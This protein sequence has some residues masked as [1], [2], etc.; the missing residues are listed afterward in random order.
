VV[1]ETLR[2]YPPAFVLA[3]RVLEPVQLDGYELE[4]NSL[5]VIPIWSLHRDA[6]FFPDPLR[7]DPDRFT[8]EAKAA[9]P[10]HAYM[11]FSYGSRNCIGE[12]FAWMEAV[13][14]LTVLL[15]R[16]QFRLAPGQKIEPQPTLTL[17]SKYGM[18]MRIG[19]RAAAASSRHSS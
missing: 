18:R 5:A 1:A 14:I 6:R 2:L 16:Y 12:H 4:P 10:R 7:F 8:P 19:A 3:R 11:P 15:S 9:R 13:L 17:R